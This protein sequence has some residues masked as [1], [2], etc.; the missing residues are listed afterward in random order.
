[1]GIA[2]RCRPVLACALSNGVPRR[3]AIV[4]FVVGTALNAINQGDAIVAGSAISWPKLL[5]TYC[6]PYLVCTYGAVS[7]SL[8]AQRCRNS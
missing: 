3:C 4:A 2:A 7:A 8:G 6:V 5:L 1:M